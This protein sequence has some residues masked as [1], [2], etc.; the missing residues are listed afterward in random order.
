MR[1]LAKF[2][3]PY[4][5]FYKLHIAIVVV[6][7]LSVAIATAASAHILKPILDELFISKDKQTLQ[8][9]PFALVGI[10]FLKGVGRYLQT[11]YTAY[12]G[13]DIVK[14]LRNRLVRHL[15]GLDLIE[16]KAMH[17]G[18]LLSRITND[19]ARLQIVASQLF[20][21]FVSS[22][23]T[24]IALVG[25]VIYQS[26]KLSFYFL[27]MMPLALLPLQRLAKKMKRH[28][29]ASQQS[30]AD[31][32]RKTNEIFQNIE[33]V[34]ANSAEPYEIG[35]F[36]EESQN[37]FLHTLRQTKINAMVGPVLELIGSAA[38]ALVIYIGA[39]EVIEGHM[40][41]GSFFAFMTA[42]F[43]LYDPIK[44]LS[45]AHNQMQDAVAVVERIKQ[46]LSKSASIK[47][48]SKDLNSVET[49]VCDN[50][51]LSLNGT[52]ILHNISHR[53]S[54]GNIYALVGSSGAGKSSFVSMLMRLYEPSSGK[55]TIDDKEIGDIKIASLHKK[56][57][58]VPQR[59][60]L[61]NDTVAANVA[62]AKEVDEKKVIE[63][64]KR[65]GA[66]E[67]VSTFKKGTFTYLDE[68][69]SNL[70]GGQRQRIALARALYS[71]PDVLILDEATA[72]LDNISEAQIMEVIEQLKKDKIIYIIAH[73]LHSIK[74]ADEV[75]FFDGGKIVAK[76]KFDELL[77][78]CDSFKE[79][80]NYSKIK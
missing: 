55:I 7:M 61:F 60:Y 15:V 45:F 21:T 32:S 26:P 2:L 8:W 62:Y 29:H 35:R 43:M 58:Y 14:R 41:V 50:V 9:L 22:L 4:V 31:M 42:L 68:A 57:A 80:V 12:V 79:F 39:L 47:D 67:F 17:S 51:S 65:S 44:K 70:S 18:E 72:A 77:S 38:I 33:I 25:Y 1:E 3:L 75:L 76:G 46:I 49:V 24:I 53:A 6:A 30:A 73:R 54:R 69:A 52:P 74:E 27:F 13:N 20:P 36:N 63:A 5:R 78:R 64:L 66:W 16:L 28:S 19:I 37:L 10:F 11:Y 56:I 48:G 40:S 34:K 71:D 23:F 59:T